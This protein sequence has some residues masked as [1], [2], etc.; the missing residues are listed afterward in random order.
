MAQ[1]EVIA[2]HVRCDS[3]EQMIL[4]LDHYLDILLKKPRAVRD[5]RVMHGTDIPE[6]VRLFHREMR[7]RHGADGDRAFVRFML[8]H[9]EVGMDAIVSV[10]HIASEQQVYHFE[11]LHELVLKQTGQV[12][13]MSSL[14]AEKLPVDLSQYRVQKADT[15]RYSALTS[16]GERG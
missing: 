1:N 14:S 8:L 13:P 7:Q 9:R 12:Q 2:T 5:A 4:V 10:L 15:S 3:R 11:G 16:G 6:V